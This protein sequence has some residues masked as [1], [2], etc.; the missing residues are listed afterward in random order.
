MKKAA[1]ILAAVM[2]L[3]LSACADKTS[4]KAEDIPALTQVEGKLDPPESPDPV[5]G[6]PPE[7]KLTPAETLVDHLRHC[8]PLSI[9]YSGESENYDSEHNA[10]LYYSGIIRDDEI[11]R[12][13][14]DFVCRVTAQDDLIPA[15]DGCVLT[16]TENILTMKTDTG[17][18]FRFGEGIL[19][20]SAG[21]DGGLPVFILT[22]PDGSSSCC[23][24]V[25]NDKQE[26][27]DLVARGIEVNENLVQILEH[28]DSRSELGLY[29]VSGLDDIAFISYYCNAAWGFCLR[30]SYV[31]KNGN[32]YEFDLS[33]VG[34]EGLAGPIQENLAQ[35]IS[36]NY[37]EAKPVRTVDPSIIAAAYEYASL[38]DR[39]AE[40]TSEHVMCDYGQN[41]LY[42][43][44][45]G[46]MIMLR[47][48][49]DVT[50]TV[51]DENADKALEILDA[52]LKRHDIRKEAQKNAPG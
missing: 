49:G 43:V 35:M 13:V 33:D 47:S 32:V 5:E 2:L 8:D 42:A 23:K 6:D 14:F 4:G 24:A 10:T 29:E 17:Y 1:F 30:G 41:T 16:D 38:V 34:F 20:G 50:K 46:C 51:L 3:S 11:R 15:A 7:E 21:D 12:S 26:L 18:R 36:K 27:Y 19:T 37:A 39:D 9:E 28:G 45:D 48:T 31:D 25:L 52:E 22:D 40:V 44:V